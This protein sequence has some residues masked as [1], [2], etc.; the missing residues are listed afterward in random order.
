[1]KLVFKW[2]MIVPLGWVRLYT[3]PRNLVPWQLDLNSTLACSLP[4]TLEWIT[5]FNRCP[6]VA[7]RNLALDALLDQVGND[8]AMYHS[9]IFCNTL[10]LTFIC[11]NIII[12]AHPLAA[13]HSTPFYYCNLFMS[14]G[15][16]AG[17]YN[18]YCI[19]SSSYTSSGGHLLQPPLAAILLLYHRCNLLWRLSYNYII[20]TTSSGGYSTLHITLT[21]LS[22]GHSTLLQFTSTLPSGC[23]SY[24]YHNLL[25]RPTYFNITFA[26]YSGGS[27]AS[28]SHFLHPSTRKKDFC[29]A[30]VCILFTGLHRLSWRFN[31][32]V[33][34][35]A[36]HG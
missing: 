29:T 1:M 27:T 33:R 35:G 34:G 14:T 9:F 3:Q 23:F 36:L 16:F 5:S 17:R 4:M 31:L 18:L 24:C 15:W 20:L 26:T 7:W 28:T 32:T 12:S 13:L 11:C 21:T 2:W 6:L 25:W 30:T 19:T 22:G 10:P 8:D